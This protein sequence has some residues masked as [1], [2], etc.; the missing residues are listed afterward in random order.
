M[1]VNY[2][3]RTVELVFEIKCLS[4]SNPTRKA[5]IGLRRLAVML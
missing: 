1:G 2:R 4:N 3:L 5:A